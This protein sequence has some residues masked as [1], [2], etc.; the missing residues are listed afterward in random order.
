MATIQDVLSGAVKIPEPPKWLV[1]GAKVRA[2]GRWPE[3]STIEVLTGITWLPKVGEELTIDYWK[4]HP[5]IPN[6]IGIVTVEHP[7][8]V[9]ALYDGD[10]LPDVR[11]QFEPV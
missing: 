8:T 11:P 10:A 5:E 7:E 3:L 2:V 1:K 6:W 9:L 4:E